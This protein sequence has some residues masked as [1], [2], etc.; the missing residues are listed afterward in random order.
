MATFTECT[1]SLTPTEELR[2]KLD[3]GKAGGYAIEPEYGCELPIGHSEP[4]HAI[5]Q[6]FN[7]GEHD[8]LWITWTDSGEPQVTALPMCDAYVEPTGGEEDKICLLY[9]GHPGPHTYER[10]VE[11]AA[12]GVLEGEGWLNG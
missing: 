1:A 2:G 10:R 6:T 11:A 9:A 4:H 8:D 5:G 12:P 3:V 7:D